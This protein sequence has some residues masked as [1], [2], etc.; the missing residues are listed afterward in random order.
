MSDP[1][2]HAN[3]I[4]IIKIIIVMNLVTNF[5]TLHIATATGALVT[6]EKAGMRLFCLFILFLIN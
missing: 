6:A 4:V 1:N 2:S 3:N 5:S